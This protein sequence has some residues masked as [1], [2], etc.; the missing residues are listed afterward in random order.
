[1]KGFEKLIKVLC[2]WEL[3]EKVSFCFYLC[4]M[5]NQKTLEIKYIRKVLMVGGS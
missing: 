3:K 2:D 1:M 4:P 5:E